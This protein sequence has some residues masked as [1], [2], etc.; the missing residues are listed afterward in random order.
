[1]WGRQSY[2]FSDFDFEAN[3]KDGVAVD[4]PIRYKDIAPWYDYAER[5]AGISGSKEGLP[6][7]PDGQFLPAD[8]TEL[9]RRKTWRPALKQHYNNKRTLIIGRTANLT[10]GTSL[11]TTG[12]PAST[13]TNAGW[14]VRL[15][16]YFS[17]QSGNAACGHEDRQPDASA[18]GRL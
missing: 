3:A 2:R 9:C 5:F 15:A 12:S 13:A 7:L 4:W 18:P 16:P 8:G 17:T 1:M 14:V 6:Q 10:E 11:N